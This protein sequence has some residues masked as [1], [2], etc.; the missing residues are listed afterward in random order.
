MLTTK[1]KELLEFIKIFIKKHSY[2]PTQREIKNAL[3]VS[4]FSSLNNNLKRLENLNLIKRKEKRAKNNISLS[5]SPFTL[6]L[7]GKIAAG[8]PIEAIIDAEEVDIFADSRYLLKVKGD[9]MIEDNIYD[10]DLIICE[11]CQKVSNGTI[12]IALINHQEATLKKIFYEKGKIYLKPANKEHKVQIY[13]PD[14]V[15][16]QGKYIGLIRLT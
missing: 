8:L 5:H 4:S 1:Q 16:I 13:N 9:S 12:V 3:N 11:R 15:E 10:G 6:P 14:E 7:L 2:A